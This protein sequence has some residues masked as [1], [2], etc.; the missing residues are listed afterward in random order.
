MTV[1]FGA[2]GVVPSGRGQP[3]Q[4]FTLQPGATRLIPAG[5]WNINL[6]LY[7]CIQELDPVQNTWVNSGGSDTNFRYVNSDG[8]SFRVANL[9]GCVVGVVVTTAGS[10]YSP[11]TPPTVTASAGSAT[12]TA[13]VGGAVSTS[14][15]VSNGGTGYVYPPLVFLDPP[16]VG[17]LGL[18]ATGYATLTSGAVSSITIDNQGSGYTNIPNIYIQND[19]RDTVGTGASAQAVLTGAG[20]I[21]SVAVTN[22]GT[23]LTTIPTLTFSSGSGA[24]TVIMVRSISGYTVTTAGSG[25]SGTVEISALGNGLNTTNV[26]TNPKWGSNLVRT[27][28]ASIIAGI[29]STSITTLGVTVLD[30][31]IYAG[32][33]PSAIIYG[34][35]TGTSVLNGAVAFTWANNNDTIQIY[36]V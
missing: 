24:G 28:K 23:P 1:I 34:G 5:T 20:T 18:Q 17:S 12:L 32:S 35:V 36:P 25:Y 6:G 2:Q 9:Q 31:G 19:P 8:N 3:T 27:R 22:I 10:G 4:A 30:G 13:V 14:V 29:S 21:T 7:S 16:P 15:T 26:L 11:A 33:A